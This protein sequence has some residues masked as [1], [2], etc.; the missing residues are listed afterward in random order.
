MIIAVDQDIPYWR[1]AFSQLGEVRPFPGRELKSDVLH[2]ADALVVRTITSVKAPLLD[3]TGVRFVAAASAGMDHVD[4]DYL[5][6]RRIQFAY[7]AGCNADSVSE[8]IMTALHVVACRRNWKLKDKSLAVI[9]VGNVGSRVAKKARALG[10]NVRL[11]DPPLRDVTGDA[12]YEPL[13]KVL[14]ADILSFHVPLSTDG[15]YPTWHMVNQEFLDRLAPEQ[16]LIN[17]SRGPVFDGPELK[18]A[19]LKGRIAGAVLDVWEEE[20]VIDYSLLEL[21]DIG[22]PHIAG[23]ALDGKIRGV[24][25]V[26]EELSRF[27]GIPSIGLSEESIYPE[28]K[29]ISPESGAN[30]QEALRSVLTQGFGLLKKDADLRTLASLPGAQAQSGFDKLRNQLPLRLEFRHFRVDLDKNQTGL[31]GTLQAMGFGVR[32][33]HRE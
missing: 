5:K 20:P 15:P 18:S 32:I 25:M 13:D 7:A 11:C 8:Y 6:D 33:G 24:E 17:T 31:A 12:Q 3:G 19:L 2:N 10:M 29:S 22:T 14:R 28:T 16:F 23:V 21:L 1:E 4:V 30:G 26:R 27:S 9:G